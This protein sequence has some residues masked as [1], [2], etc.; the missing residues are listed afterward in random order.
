MFG[1]VYPLKRLAACISQQPRLRLLLGQRLRRFLD[2]HL[3]LAGQVR[4]RREVVISM[5][6]SLVPPDHVLVSLV[7]F[8]AC[9]HWAVEATLIATL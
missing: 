2:V 1:P 6:H 7:D 3:V 4:N 9:S 5:V 8:I